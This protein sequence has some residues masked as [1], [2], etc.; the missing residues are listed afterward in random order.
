MEEFQFY[1][2]RIVKCEEREVLNIMANTKDEAKNIAKKAAMLGT[3]FLDVTAES[4]FEL[5]YETLSPLLNQSGEAIV[6]V[7]DP[8][9]NVCFF[10]NR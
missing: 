3:E 10:T 6:S 9:T 2:N 4:E 5:V 7:V 1:I 8:A